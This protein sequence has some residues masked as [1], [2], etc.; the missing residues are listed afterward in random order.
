MTFNIWDT[1]GQEKFGGLRE[2]NYIGADCAIVMFDVTSRMS[3][4]N[5]RVWAQDLRKHA[6]PG[7][8]IVLCGNK[9]DV[10]DRKVKPK[11]I[12]VH[13]DPALGFA[14]Y[15][16]ISAKSNHNF[17]KPFLALAKHFFG[18]DTTLHTIADE[19]NPPPDGPISSRLRSRR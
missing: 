10:K 1:A 14:A 18:N 13:R 17:E 9:V 2:G 6:P 3:Y 7:I 19:P 15:F 12:V 11:H 4:K 16:D 8:P 5:A